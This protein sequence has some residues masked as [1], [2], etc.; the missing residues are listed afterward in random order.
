MFSAAYVCVSA[1]LFVMLLTCE[2]LDA[3]S[4]LLARKYILRI[5]RSS[6]TSRSSGQGHRSKK[7]P[8]RPIRALNLDCFDLECPLFVRRYIFGITVKFAYQ[9]Q[10]VRHKKVCLCILYVGGLP[11][12]ERQASYHS[13]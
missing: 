11:L 2:N 4:S 12:I 3:E 9:G 7:A 10:T 8:V 1:C 5:L 6:C 13:T